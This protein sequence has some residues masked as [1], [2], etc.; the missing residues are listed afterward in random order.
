MNLTQFCCIASY[1]L[2]GVCSILIFVSEFAF[3]SRFLNQAIPDSIFRD[4]IS[5]T[6]HCSQH[7]KLMKLLR[8]VYPTPVYLNVSYFPEWMTS[9]CPEVVSHFIR[10]PYFT[11]FVDSIPIMTTL[12]ACHSVC[13][14][15]IALQIASME[16]IPMYLHAGSHLGAILHAGPIPW[17]DDVD[18]LV[19]YSK[20][21]VFFQLCVNISRSHSHFHGVAVECFQH[22]NALKFSV[23]S[24]HSV[25][26]SLGWKSP[27]L[28]V[29]FYRQNQTHLEEVS[30]TGN[31]HML[32][33][34]SSSYLVLKFYYFGGL[35]VYGPDESISKYRYNLQRCVMSPYNHRFEKTHSFSKNQTLDCCELSRH[36][37][38]RISETH[39]KVGVHKSF[40]PLAK[41]EKLLKPAIENKFTT[42]V[43]GKHDH[44]S[45]KAPYWRSP[46]TSPS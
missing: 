12:F 19:P 17:D 38:F 44:N 6:I 23:V 35:Y 43:N 28:D 5:S 30:P 11:D 29:F 14:L 20:S 18:V 10:F 40:V 32:H 9:L 42:S 26:T 45:L 2:L 3:E 36:F 4:E 37:P 1:L 46:S 15:K 31:S 34:P 13:T 16:N 39:V 24:K 33:F 21:K 8:P 22:V 27:F 7:E 41:S 25:L